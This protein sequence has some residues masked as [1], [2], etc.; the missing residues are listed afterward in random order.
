[1]SSWNQGRKM[2]GLQSL[3]K[4]KV[5]WHRDA[6]LPVR[7]GVQWIWMNP[8]ALYPGWPNIIQGVELYDLSGTLISTGDTTSIGNSTFEVSF[9]NVCPNSTTTYIVKSKYENANVPGT[10]VYGTD[11]VRAI[12]QSP[13]SATSSAV[14]A[15]LPQQQYRICDH[16]TI[17]CRRSVWIFNW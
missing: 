14:A 15:S 11:T 5:S 8:G 3:D 6:H 10:F 9:P 1:M 13:L 17:R 4:T 2:I 12:V 16:Y 7:H